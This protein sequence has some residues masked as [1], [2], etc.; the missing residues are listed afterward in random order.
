MVLRSMIN[1]LRLKQIV[2]DRSEGGS[3]VPVLRFGVG[4]HTLLGFL[5]SLRLDKGDA[6]WSTEC[7]LNREKNST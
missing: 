3:L 5:V 7:S 4:G 1:I 6:C 2:W